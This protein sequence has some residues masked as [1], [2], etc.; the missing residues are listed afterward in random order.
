MHGILALKPIYQATL[1]I[2][3][4]TDITNADKAQEEA[5]STRYRL[6]QVDFL[7]A[8]KLIHGCTNV[9]CKQ[10]VM[11]KDIS[12]TSLMTIKFL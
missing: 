12:S 2:S 10:K 6:I 3:Q 7:I 8:D 4:W 1:D 11:K 5:H 9:E